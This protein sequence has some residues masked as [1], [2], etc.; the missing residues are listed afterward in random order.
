LTE[1]ELGVEMGDLLAGWC[2][3]ASV[4]AKDEVGDSR[5]YNHLSS[6]P[7]YHDLHQSISPSVLT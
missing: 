4:A 2:K 6:H 5:E 3:R 1:V 7:I